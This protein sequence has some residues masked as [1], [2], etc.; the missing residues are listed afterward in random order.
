MPWLL[1]RE[2]LRDRRCL[3]NL[4]SITYNQNSPEEVYPILENTW[5][6]WYQWWF[7]HF[8]LLNLN[9]ISHSLTCFKYS[10]YHSC[11]VQILGFREEEKSI[12]M[13]NEQ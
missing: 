9:S 2:N 12:S 7:S 6:N 4:L 3:L 5:L 13:N 8:P 10:V 1:G 11:E